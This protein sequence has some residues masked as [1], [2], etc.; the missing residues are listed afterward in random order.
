M[1]KTKFWQK[2]ASS[3]PASIRARHLDDIARAER[4]EMLLE[5]VIDACSRLKSSFAAQRPTHQH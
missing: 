3:L 5:G 4:F 1:L 2:A